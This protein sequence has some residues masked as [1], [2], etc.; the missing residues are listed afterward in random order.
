MDFAIVSHLA[1]IKSEHP[2][3]NCF[4]GFRTSHTIKKCEIIDYERLKDY[5]PWAEIEKFKTRA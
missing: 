3:I 5:V 1:A 4:D 2:V